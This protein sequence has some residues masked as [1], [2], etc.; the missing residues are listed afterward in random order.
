MMPINKKRTAA[1]MQGPWS[2]LLGQFK[3]IRDNLVSVGVSFNEQGEAVDKNNKRVIEG[4]VLF[5]KFKGSVADLPKIYKESG[6]SIEGIV[7]K[8]KEL[9]KLQI[10]YATSKFII[11]AE[12]QKIALY[13]LEIEKGSINAIN[14]KY[15]ANRKITEQKVIQVNQQ[16][17][18]TKQLLVQGKNS[19]SLLEKINSL[20]SK[21]TTIIETSIE[22]Y[23]KIRQE[24][25]VINKLFDKKKS[26]IEIEIVSSESLIEVAKAS[27]NDTT[28]ILSNRIAALYGLEES[29]L[30][31]IMLSWNIANANIDRLDQIR[32]KSGALSSKQEAE[33]EKSKNTISTTDIRTA[34]VIKDSL[35]REMAL[36]KEKYTLQVATNEL[37]KASNISAINFSILK[38]NNANITF[39]ERLRFMKKEESL[40]LKNSKLDEKTLN[41]KINANNSDIIFLNKHANLDKDNLIRSKLLLDNRKLTTEHLQTQLQYDQKSLDISIEKHELMK[42]NLSLGDSGF[43]DTVQKELDMMHI[44]FRKNM[45]TD[46]KSVVR[47]IREPIT[48]ALDALTNGLLEGSK[49]V[50]QIL[51]DT[52][53][54][55]YD[56]IV[57]IIMTKVG[58]N[59]Q[60]A[61]LNWAKSSTS[62]SSLFGDTGVDKKLIV[63]ESQLTVLGEI[64]AV[65]SGM[66]SSMGSSVATSSSGGSSWVG[67]IIKGVIGAY[68]GSAG[69]SS[70]LDSMSGTSG[71]YADAFD[72]FKFKNGGIMSSLGAMQVNTYKN[73]GVATSPQV[74]VFGEGRQNEAYV[75]LPDNRTIPVTL[76]G[77]Q[78]NQTININI[79]IEADGNTTEDSDSSNNTAKQLGA[80]IS[81]AVQNEMLQQSRPGGLLYK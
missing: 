16:I 21:R 73:G 63:A 50:S 34:K 64:F 81:G 3:V 36:L 35:N 54:A 12:S 72:S 57:D 28:E 68:T 14:L 6:K 61:L 33:L 76:K 9:Q 41:N 29:Q 30:N 60:D 15:I 66:A 43:V 70:S 45:Q 80:L 27:I 75:P 42:E 32:K 4:H 19:K 11:D 38:R 71:T 74:S 5:E 53:K 31:N 49:T 10:E 22:K 46:A 56:S 58:D 37:E 13:N 8:Y 17:A 48:S 39:H 62:L 7:V 1:G 59:F 47:F 52:L 78:N 67:T 24:L 23:S 65:I 69:S 79:N 18:R 26:S 20:E 25:E 51:M 77:G 44:S 55:G 2:S 40:L